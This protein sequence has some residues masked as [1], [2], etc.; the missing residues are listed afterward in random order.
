MEKVSWIEIV[1]PKKWL[2]AC[3]IFFIAF[4]LSVNGCGSGIDSSL[5]SSII[6]DPC[7]A[8]GFDPVEQQALM[9]T[10]ARDSYYISYD[11]ERQTAI[12]ACW[13]S[14]VSAYQADNCV[15]C[16]VPLINFVYSP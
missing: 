15:A 2:L 14:S 3:L 5:S 16:V 10:V 13:N 12:D 9:D 4:A 7:L 1:T 8:A 11:D 6:P